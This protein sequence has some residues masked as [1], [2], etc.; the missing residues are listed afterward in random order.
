MVTQPGDGQPRQIG[1]DARRYYPVGHNACLWGDPWCLVQAPS[2]SFPGVGSRRLT[3][4]RTVARSSQA[5]P[6]ALFGGQ[7]RLPDPVPVVVHAGTAAILP[8]QH[9]DD[10]DVI[11]AV[12]LCRH[13]HRCKQAEGWQ[14]E[15]PEPG[16]LVWRT[17]SGRTYASTPSI[18]SV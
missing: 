4:S 12:P 7:A 13:H 11:V 15:Q 3:R 9:R 2:A 18:Y 6:V 5:Q 1:R 8:G 17:P 16:V 14:L 10:V